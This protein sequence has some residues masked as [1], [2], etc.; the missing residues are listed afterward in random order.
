MWHTNGRPTIHLYNTLGKTKQRFEL[1]SQAKEVRM[2]HCGPTVYGRQH[3]GNLS[4]FV[5][6]D[7]LRRVLEYN[8]FKVKQV[9]NF[10][11]FGHLSSDAD[12]G[13]DKMTK[14]L[15]R[16]G[17][18]FTLDNMKA[19]GEKYANLFLEDIRALNV[20]VEGT[21]FPR[22]SGYISA[23]IAMIQTLE[24]KGY[25]YRTGRGV[26]FDTKRFPEYGR[27]GDIDL[28]SLRAGARVTSDPEKRS[29]TDFILWKSDE[30]LGWESPWGM[31]FPGWHIECSAMIRATLGQQID[32]HTGGV[33]HIAVHHNNEI[34]QSE[35]ATGK[36][37]LSRF[38]MHRAHIRFEGGKMAKSEGN[39]I[40]LSDIVERGFHPLALR[41]LFLTAHYR[42]PSSFSWEALEAAQKA[43]SKLVALRLSLKDAKSGTTPREWRKKFLARINDDLDTPGALALLWGMTKDK[44]LAPGDLL[45]GLLDFDAIFGLGLDEPNETGMKL[46]QADMREAIPVETLPETIRAFVREREEARKKKDWTR[47]DE[48]RVLI[49]S[50]GYAIKDMPEGSHLYRT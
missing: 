43:F 14:G 24:E 41:Y 7:I 10:T 21:T 37:P 5:F 50:E 33:E 11:D 39:V 3:I 9:I 47:A 8:D 34:A 6:T 22:A 45:A 20:R 23:Q 13:E 28:S 4:M 26:Y 15:K 35:S 46:A 12:E 29:T 38:W 19:L 42:T 48:L 40:Y 27:L 49:E 30:K 32:I 44:H 36:K 18:A 31:G 2:Y 25:A 1:P 16:E 17:L